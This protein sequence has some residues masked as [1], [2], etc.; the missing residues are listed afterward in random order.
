MS[1]IRELEFFEPV[2]V[3]PYDWADDAENPILEYDDFIKVKD[4]IKVGRCDAAALLPDGR[5]AI[6]GGDQKAVFERLKW[7]RTYTARPF[8]LM[9][10]IAVMY[11]AHDPL[12][13]ITDSHTALYVAFADPASRAAYCEQFELSEA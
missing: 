1:E 5:V 13:K 4:F 10:D 6:H 8:A 9:L 11:D 7:L 2:I 3:R 12:K